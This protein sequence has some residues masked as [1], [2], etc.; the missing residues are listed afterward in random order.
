MEETLRF[1]RSS[2]QAPQ[3]IASGRLQLL[4]TFLESDIQDPVTGRELLDA[5][6]SALADRLEEFEMSGNAFT[7]HLDGEQARITSLFDENQPGLNLPAELF[8]RSL[9]GWIEFL[10]LKNLLVM[11][12]HLG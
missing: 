10:S 3:I 4:A 5:F 8:T 7:I 6:Q 12:P 9:E 2:Q 11:Q 1:V